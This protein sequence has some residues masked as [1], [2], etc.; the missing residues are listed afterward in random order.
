MTVHIFSWP[1]SWGD[2]VLKVN[3]V[4][5]VQNLFSPHPHNII[6]WYIISYI[7][8]YIIY[9]YHD[10]I[11]FLIF[12][13]HLLLSPSVLSILWAW[14][15]AGEQPPACLPVFLTGVGPPSRKLDVQKNLKILLVAL[16]ATLLNILSTP[17]WTAEH[18]HS[19]FCFRGGLSWVV[20]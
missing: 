2:D 19:R 16:Q 6:P 10:I 7:I 3:E 8:S 12:S 17:L 14:G 18:K 9:T 15:K 11:Y 20:L 5:Y 4:K 1:F 13:F